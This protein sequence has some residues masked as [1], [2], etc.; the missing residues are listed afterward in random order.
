MAEFRLRPAL[1]N[2]KHM[3]L[4][5]KSGIV[6]TLFDYA[7]V[8]YTGPDNGRNE[9]AL[10]GRP[11]MP[12]GVPVMIEKK[13]LSKVLR[14]GLYAEWWSIPGQIEMFE[15]EHPEPETE[16]EVEEHPEPETESEEK[17]QT[18]EEALTVEETPRPKSRR[19]FAP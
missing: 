11:F 10:N 5:L 13:Q 3:R 18:L 19:K 4:E 1:H 2:H 15:D 8:V 7:F 9:S 16:P 17:P 12:K 6:E 14:T